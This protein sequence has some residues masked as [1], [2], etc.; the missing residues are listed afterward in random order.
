MNTRLAS[1]LTLTHTFTPR[2]NLAGSFYLPV[3]FLIGR[4]KP[5]NPDVGTKTNIKNSK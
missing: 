1:T 2:S 4:R 3:M 5:D